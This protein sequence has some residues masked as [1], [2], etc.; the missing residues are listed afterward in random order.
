MDDKRRGISVDGS[1]TSAVPV[2]AVAAAAAADPVAP[3]VREIP[4][5][6]PERSYFA[7]ITG[8]RYLTTAVDV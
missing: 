7:G 8:G 5:R 3:R 2:A 4:T 6:F 1:Y